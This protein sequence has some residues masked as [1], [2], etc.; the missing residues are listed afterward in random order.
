[1]QRKAKKPVKTPKKRIRYCFDEDASFLAK[2]SGHSP[3]YFTEYFKDGRGLMCNE[4]YVLFFPLINGARIEEIFVKKKRKTLATQ[5]ITRLEVDIID[6]GGCTIEYKVKEI[7]LET[8]LFL[9]SMDYRAMNIVETS[10]GV[11]YL[12]KKFILTPKE[13]VKD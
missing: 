6:Q 8:Q 7:D 2:L 5:L 9:K 1:M 13:N 12:F 4:G 10:K 11:Y 3:Q